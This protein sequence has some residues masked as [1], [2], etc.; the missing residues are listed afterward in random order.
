VAPTATLA[1]GTAVPPTSSPYSAGEQAQVCQ[2]GPTEPNGD[3]TYTTPLRDI[4]GLVTDITGDPGVIPD[5]P[6][7]V[8]EPA[9]WQLMLVAGAC[10]PFA[11]RFRRKA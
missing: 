6:P 1:D 11:R 10:M 9:A 2:S 3:G 4:G 5:D 8:P 7:G